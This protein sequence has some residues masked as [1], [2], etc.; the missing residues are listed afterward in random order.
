M[1]PSDQV[2]ALPGA[3]FPVSF[4]ASRSRLKGWV[5][6]LSN[7]WPSVAVEEVSVGPSGEPMTIL[8]AEA[9]RRRALVI[10]VAG[11][12]GVEGYAGSA[13]A[14]VFLRECVPGLDEGSVSV[15]VVHATNPW[16]WMTGRKTNHD[17]VDL[18]RSFLA[19]RSALPVNSGYS[20]PAICSV[21]EPSRPLGWA[22]LAARLLPLALRGRLGALAAALTLGQYHSPQGLYHGGSEAPQAA[23][24]LQAAFDRALDEWDELTVLDLHTGY[25]P[26]D[27]LAVVNSRYENTP[28]QEWARRLDWPLVQQSGNDFYAIH[29]D[30]TDWLT[31]R[32]RQRTPAKSFWATT[33]EFGTWG[34]GTLPML[35]TLAATVN[36]NAAWHH[37]TDAQ[38]HR[39]GRALRSLYAPARPRWRRAV[40]D[41]ARRLLHTIVEV[42]GL[43]RGT[44]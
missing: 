37:G 25:G 23:V 4:E 33:L 36:E 14:E 18:N 39:W 22:A 32:H 29:G 34:D 30:M 42:R 27:A 15:W 10:L 2:A 6:A 1:A 35:R 9:P 19:D 28:A 17:N 40:I 12:H 5:T 41:Q 38:K 16:G 3:L 43:G 11:L 44:P 31:L 8:R 13:V 26:K 21:F 20:D 24:W 7:R